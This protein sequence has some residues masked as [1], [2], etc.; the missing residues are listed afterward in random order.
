MAQVYFISADKLK[1]D[2]VINENTDNK[3]ISP[4]ILMAQDIYIQSILGTSLYTEL[5]NQIQNNTVST[6]NQTLLT[7]YLQ[8][9]IKYYC[10]AELTTPLTYKFMNKSIVVKN[11]ENSTTV[12]P[13]QLS[14]IKNY[15]LNHA[16]WYAKRIVKYLQENQTQYPLWLGGNTAIDDIQPRTNTY[17]TGMFLGNTR[18]NSGW[19]TSLPV[20]NGEKECC[21]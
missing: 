18:K 8:T 5:K 10:M 3:L 9:A 4:T 6:L 14:Q 17:T 2:T 13:E 16:E 1:E 7:D 12:S 19:G 21:D 20:D 15:Y 11:S